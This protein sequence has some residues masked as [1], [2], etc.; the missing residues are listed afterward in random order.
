LSRQRFFCIPPPPLQKNRPFISATPNRHPLNF[1]LVGKTFF[2]SP[3]FISTPQ[4]PLGVLIPTSRT[5]PHLPPFNPTEPYPFFLPPP[6]VFINP[7]GIKTAS[8][9]KSLPV[10]FPSA[11]GN[12]WSSQPFLFFFFCRPLWP[13]PHE[14]LD[15]QP[16]RQP[17]NAQ[18]Y[19]LFLRSQQRSPFRSQVPAVPVVVP[20]SANSFTR[21]CISIK[22]RRP[23]SDVFCRLLSQLP[24]VLLWALTLPILK[25]SPTKT[26]NCFGLPPQ[27]FFTDPSF[28]WKDFSFRLRPLSSPA[29]QE[30]VLSPSDRDILLLPMDGFSSE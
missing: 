13:P 5:P 21:E 17:T 11:V 25:P 12:P 16:R 26:P 8:D 19:A 22:A 27:H 18:W 29:Y 3:S 7:C 28:P 30:I 9:L 20:R 4:P 1:L 24:D 14:K 10:F 15:E 2:S 23:F 6:S